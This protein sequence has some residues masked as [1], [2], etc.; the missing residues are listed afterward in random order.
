MLENIIS[1]ETIPADG[2]Q[3]QWDIP[4]TF[5]KIADVGFYVSYDNGK[6]IEKI[7]QNIRYEKDGNY[8]VYPTEE[9]KL[10]V[11]PVGATVLLLRETE[12]KQ[13]ETSE[14]FPF[15][16]KDIER[17]ADNLTMQIQDLKRDSLRS[18]KS[19]L[20]SE[21]TGEEF[22]E[23]FFEKANEAIASANDAK[24]AASDAEESNQESLLNAQNAASSAVLA[25]SASESAREHANAAKNDA[26]RAEAAKV[27][28]EE[29][30]AAAEAFATRSENASE[31][32]KKYSE[33]AKQSVIDAEQFAISAAASAES[34]K[35]SADLAEEL[36]K[37]LD[38][39]VYTKEEIDNKVTVIDSAIDA[40]AEAIQ[41]T[42]NDFIKADS[43]L[44]QQINAHAEELTTHRN[45]IDELGD[46]VAEI[47]SKIPEGT[48]DTNPLI[49]K[50]QLLDEEM[51]IRE[52][53]MES[54]SELQT[55]INALAE[56]IQGGGG[57]SVPDN[58]YTQDNLIAGKNVTFTEVLPEGGIDEHTLAC[59][60]F[61]GNQIDEVSGKVFSNQ[62][63][64]FPLGKFNNS[65]FADYNVI[66]SNYT[67]SANLFPDIKTHSMAQFTIDFWFSLNS[68]S[69]YA[70][71]CTGNN[72]T[73]AS[74]I[75]YAKISPFSILLSDEAYDGGYHNI[76]ETYTFPETLTY[77]KYYHAALQVNNFVAKV[78]F[79][80]K[81]ML[82]AD[83]T[84][85]GLSSTTTGFVVRG[86]A[87]KIDELRISDCVR[88]TESF[89]PPTKAYTVATGPS[90]TAV[91][92]A[93]P[94]KLSELEND[95]GFITGGGSAEIP[96][97]VY[98]AENL[99]AGD[100]I[101]FAP[102]NAMLNADIVGSPVISD[103]YE[104]SGFSDSNYL[105][106]VDP[107]ASTSKYDSFEIGFAFKANTLNT[108]NAG[109]YDSGSN[110][111][112]GYRITLTTDG[113]IRTRIITDSSGSYGI[114]ITG[115]TTLATN[116]KYYA[117]LNYSSETGYTLSL[118]EEGGEWV[119]DASATTTTK[120]Y[121]NEEIDILIG[122]NKAT[123]YSFNGTI[124]LPEMYINIDGKRVW[125][126]IIPDRI[127]VSVDNV[128]TPANLLGGKDIEI[129]PEPVEGGIDEHTLACWHFD[130]DSK[131]VVSGSSFN[132][133]TGLNTTY[134]KFGTA[135]SY[136]LYATDL[137]NVK[138]AQRTI[139]FW[140]FNEPWNSS[141]VL[142]VGIAAGKYQ[143]DIDG[144]V[145][146]ISNT[147]IRF[148]KFKYSGSTWDERASVDYQPSS[149][150]FTHFAAQRVSSSVFQ[151]FINGKKIIDVDVETD[152]LSENLSIDCAGGTPASFHIDELRISDCVRYT[153]DF[154][155]PTQPYRLAVPTGNYMVNFTGKADGSNASFP[156]FYHT[157]T[158]HILNNASWL[159][160][161]TFSWQSGDMYVSAYNHLAE[162]LEGITAETETIGSTTI[163]FYRA[164]D[165]HK[166]VLADQES[167]VAAIYAETGVAWY[168]ILD[169]ENKQF[170]LPRDGNRFRL[171]ANKEL[172]DW[173]K[174]ETISNGFVAPSSGFVV[175]GVQANDNNYY[176]YVTPK[177]GTQVSVYGGYNNDAGGQWSFIVNEGD[178]FSASA[179]NNGIFVPFLPSVKGVEEDNKKYLYFYVGN[180]ILNQTEVDVGAVTE[181]MN[182]KA[183]VDL[184]NVTD[185]GKET[186][187]SWVMPDYE[188]GI[189]ITNIAA[190]VFVQVEKDSF[191]VVF[192]SDS[193]AED[194]YAY[195]SPDGGTTKYIVG[196]RTDDTG[197]NTQTISFPFFVPAGWYFSNGA[198]NGGSAFI[199]PLIGVKK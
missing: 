79:D 60:H 176:A 191:V 183:D 9:S 108:D 93:V 173:D 148:G 132:A 199:Y 192:G 61:D 174:Q 57:G 143:N 107:I 189:E 127:A 180:T 81:E 124:Y 46:E 77:G 150:E 65:V 4:F 80:G 157:F 6:T 34:A 58:V 137:S 177:G 70:I 62:N 78:F 51:D 28:N 162:D 53:M 56:A 7:T 184:G 37:D 194:Y 187:I 66:Q 33:D 102:K 91:N 167:N 35:N 83:F 190:N 181:Q 178:T 30:L 186:A 116:K 68:S 64:S 119:V 69:S 99:V 110:V 47:E 185:E 95:T 169:A 149:T 136:V 101:V 123:G 32:S 92:A 114:D 14:T 3:R 73:N 19:S 1:K 141:S 146:L 8:F 21:E 2:V 49:N 18:V 195:V 117:K 133:S 74:N 155:P 166:I 82:S 104:A 163:T 172:L 48:S 43:E 160:S 121:P 147:Q 94:T 125:A 55:Q 109:I 26:D 153:E 36:I 39:G 179:F 158:D 198:E 161:D 128:Y 139:D 50:Q 168:Y 85:A 159:L 145:V 197:S 144:W 130:G 164:T 131:D 31:E 52:D 90:K 75:Y 44:Q 63:Y 12:N 140:Y 120:P 54:D 13:L 152:T 118:K 171:E 98:T 103:N 27:N 20:F 87:S 129:I 38:A 42:R 15:N 113:K 22:A 106:F 193:Y 170:K 182:S 97:N 111:G 40:N 151:I 165:G 41:K 29:V 76:K 11:L 154:T 142:W 115:A 188:N 25:T 23:R 16:S 24:K 67:D 156:L 126:G 122:D 17:M 112:S 96:D 71:A 135:S 105:K 196:R 89:T 5:Y 59:W 86:L 100:N 84:S 175:V 45:D 10:P 138:T 88:Y 134:K 72:A